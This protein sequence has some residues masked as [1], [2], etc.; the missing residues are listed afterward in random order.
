MGLMVRYWKTRVMKVALR[1]HNI[2]LPSA[3]MHRWGGTQPPIFLTDVRVQVD[4]HLRVIQDGLEFLISMIEKQEQPIS[5]FGFEVS[6]KL[7][8]SILALLASAVISFLWRKYQVKLKEV[9]G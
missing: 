1:S 9:F 5:I 8:S 2:E 7:Q 4:S 6:Y 3:D